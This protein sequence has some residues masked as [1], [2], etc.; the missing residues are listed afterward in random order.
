M[1]LMA[2]I[3]RAF[4]L[5]HGGKGGVCVGAWKEKKTEV[6]VKDKRTI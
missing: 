6:R 3:I 1:P 4:L 5:P 2:K